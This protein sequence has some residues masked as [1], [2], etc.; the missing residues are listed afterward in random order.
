MRRKYREVIR[1]MESSPHQLSSPSFA[2]LGTGFNIVDKDVTP[3]NKP[4]F[5]TERETGKF[6]MMVFLKLTDKSYVAKIEKLKVETERATGNE[7]VLSSNTNNIN[8][9]NNSNNDRFQK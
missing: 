2:F 1:D 3:I 5:A 4:M 6:N 8:N 7:C 9:N